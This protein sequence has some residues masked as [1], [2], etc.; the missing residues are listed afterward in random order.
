VLHEVLPRA[1]LA[2]EEGKVSVDEFV[3]PR[4][5]VAIAVIIVVARLMG[6]LFKQLRQPPVV[7]E[8]VGG[9]LLGP[10]FLGLFPGDLD[11]LLFPEE[12]RD[13]LK[14]IA[15]VGLVI[16]MFIVG[17]ELDMKLIRGKERVAGI[18][19]ISSI[20]LP[21]G[22]GIL[23]ALGIHG[24]H[25]VVLVEGV[26]EE[27]DVLPFALFMGAAMSITA[28]PVLA[29]ILTDRGMYRT[30]I[31]ALT[32]ACAAVDDVIAWSLL[33]IVLAVVDSSGFGDFPRIVGLSVLFVGGMFL[34]VKPLLERYVVGAW[35]RTGK[36]TPT[37]LAIII[38]GILLSGWATAE[39][40]I[41]H[42]FGA[43][44][45]GAIMPRRDTHALFHDVLDRLEQM[46]IILLLPVFFVAT[47]LNVRINDLPLEDVPIVLAILATAVV[48]KFVGATLAARAQRLPWSKAAA[49]GTLMN[50]RGLTELVILNVGREKG[51]LDDELFTMMVIMAVVTTVMTE[52]LLRLFY[53]D[54]LL[55]R[56]VAEAARHALEAE[57]FRIVAVVDDDDTA[58][59]LVDVAA[60]IAGPHVADLPVELI[61]TRFTPFQGDSQLGLGVGLGHQLDEMAESLRG[62][63]DLAATAEAR[64]VRVSVRSQF[65]DDPVRD[66]LA[67]LE[68]IDADVV[69][70]AATG[71]EASTVADGLLDAAPCDVGVVHLGAADRGPGYLAASVAGGAHGAAVAEL[72]ARVAVAAGVP[73]ELVDDHGRS[74]RRLGTVH[75]L[76][77]R[78]DVPA[79]VE[80]APDGL[81]HHLVAGPG[82]GG[83]EERDGPWPVVLL[84]A[85]HAD[86]AAAVAA[87]GR[88]V[89][90]VRGK[91]GGDDTRLE[92]FAVTVR[93]VDGERRLREAEDRDAHRPSATT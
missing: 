1:L 48:G 69:L 85:D 40:G 64:G 2:T 54:R 53:P 82:P 45:F 35:R 47:G 27:V 33:A 61:I 84:A 11:T 5:L 73:V 43:F 60:A 63:H 80:S 25:D 42:I 81:Q 26:P 12:I 66:L 34:I 9:I 18:I 49:I 16:F 74:G 7:G 56:D 19:S 55:Q 93:E 78:A 57:A 41:H 86:G 20:L 39:I 88:S 87:A 38:V 67:Q 52:P 15:N 6:A 92:Q 50:T 3:L 44:V 75:K 65:S 71:G 4:T 14:V 58:A 31:G 59:G 22:L 89:I 77:G 13:F 28:F 30:Q 91:E 32:L 68:A 37:V 29:R 10:T 70:V 79:F 76:L 8:I 23:L 46:T 83:V 24:D 17:L 62:L 90:V 72:A 21:F 51:V 36:L